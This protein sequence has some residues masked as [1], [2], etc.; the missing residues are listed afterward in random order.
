L[1]RNQTLLPHVIAV[2]KKHDTLD[3]ATAPTP[4]IRTAH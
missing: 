3:S 2:K 1:L 4:I